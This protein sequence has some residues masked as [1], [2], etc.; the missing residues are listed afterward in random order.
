MMKHLFLLTLFF[1]SSFNARTQWSDCDN[2]NF[3]G[4]SPQVLEVVDDTLIVGGFFAS[5]NNVG[6][7]GIAKWDGLTWSDLP[8]SQGVED[9]VLFGDSLIFAGG[10]YEQMENEECGAIGAYFN[11]EWRGLAG[12]A[13]S[14]SAVVRGISVLD[15]K[16]IAV[17]NFNE[18]GGVESLWRVGM[19]DGN[20]WNDIGGVSG[21]IGE[22]RK[23]TNYNGEIYVCGDF[24]FADGDVP[25]PNLARW[26]G[27]EWNEVESGPSS[28][29]LEIYPFP[30]HGYMYVGGLFSNVNGEPSPG[31][32]KF[33]GVNTTP[34]S[35]IGFNDA[36][37]A[38]C[39]YR[40]QIYAAGN[41]TQ[42]SD[43][44]EMNH[45]ARFD[46]VHWQSLEGGIGG[47]VFDLEI[48]QDHL[49]AVGAIEW[50]GSEDYEIDG[51]TR[52]FMHPDSV[53]WGVPDNI[54][55]LQFERGSF[56]VFPN[57]TCT[58]CTIMNRT[59]IDGLVVLTTAQGNEL[60]RRRIRSYQEIHIETD[61][62]PTG[63]YFVS[64]VEM[65]K[66]VNTKRLIKN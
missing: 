25:S 5:V 36:A 2:A 21:F 55:N 66:I 60:L 40:D 56:E 16:L 14:P 49:Y 15:D 42:L 28:T 19:W 44:T 35:T 12:G 26:N 54:Y 20:Q 29:V 45:I 41:F 47:N 13:D 8:N 58:S 3:V 63:T 17:G 53:T 32:A 62:M 23:V 9:I 22:P 52:W 37:K 38:I 24:A 39:V 30:D 48:Y 18:L 7:N 51:M 31:I 6:F 1:A 61:S 11:G 10:F 34:F 46:G 64:L 43:G 50:A 65:G 59:A 4:L 27:V 57:P 33:D